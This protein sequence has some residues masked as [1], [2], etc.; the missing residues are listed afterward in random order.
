MSSGGSSSNQKKDPKYQNVLEFS[1]LPITVTDSFSLAKVKKPIPTPRKTSLT[2]IAAQVDNSSSTEEDDDDD[3]Y[4]PM[5]TSISKMQDSHLR[6]EISIRQQTDLPPLLNFTKPHSQNEITAHALEKADDVTFF[7]SSEHK[8][9]LDAANSSNRDK[10]I[11]GFS[12]NSDN[13]DSTEYYL[14]IL[15]ADQKRKNNPTIQSQADGGGNVIHRRIATEKNGHDWKRSQGSIFAEEM[16]DFYYLSPSSVEDKKNRASS[17]SYMEIDESRLRKY[18]A[19]AMSPTNSND[20]VY[21]QAEQDTYIIVQ[22]SSSSDDDYTCSNLDKEVRCPISPPDLIPKSKSLLREL[23]EPVQEQQSPLEHPR[24]SKKSPNLIKALKT[25]QFVINKK[26]KKLLPV[27]SSPRLPLYPPSMKTENLSESEVDSTSSR[28]NELSGRHFISKS[29]SLSPLPIVES[30]SLID[31][32]LTTE[33]DYIEID[34][35]LSS[36]SPPSPCNI[37]RTSSDAV[38]HINPSLR[39]RRLSSSNSNSGSGPDDNDVIA[40]TA[41]KQTYQLNTVGGSSRLR[42]IED[43]NNYTNKRMVGYFTS[44]GGTLQSRESGVY[45]VVPV[46]AIQNGK[47][48]KLWFVL[49]FLLKVDASKVLLFLSGLKF[50]SQS[51]SKEKKHFK[52]ACHMFSQKRCNVL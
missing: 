47:R 42:G 35:P 38:M 52:R 7:S 12:D 14:P 27:I 48:Q 26:K 51:V 10:V 34:R 30:A 23:D 40:A 17:H 1:N 33:T 15:P 29:L 37:Y 16:I 21:V 43:S 18:P 6:N 36:S 39:Q 22:H 50:F 4:T 49:K 44:Q 2:V 3:D 25:Q 31:E 32:C 28:F 46:D 45:M 9:V 41:N 5:S 11:I 24:K 8:K 20:P 13:E 19:R